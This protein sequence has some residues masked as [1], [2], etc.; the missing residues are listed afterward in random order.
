MEY[1]TADNVRDAVYALADL[2]SSA[3]RN[4]LL[5]LIHFDYRYHT[6][7]GDS[8]IFVGWDHVG[9]WP[10]RTVK[11]FRKRLSSKKLQWTLANLWIRLRLSK[12][13]LLF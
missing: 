13:N 2:N 6:D 4:C 3:I 12:F 8:F 10:P 9:L 5:N 11:E 1:N 7:T